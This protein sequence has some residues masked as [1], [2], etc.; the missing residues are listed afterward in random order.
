MPDLKG[1]YFR[2]GLNRYLGSGTT[3]LRNT[4]SKVRVSRGTAPLAVPST[5][6]TAK[7]ANTIAEINPV[8]AIVLR[9]SDYF[10]AASLH[11]SI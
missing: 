4:L 1:S 9:T 11:E 6:R 3:I 2:I 8:K 10:L 7:V 5:L